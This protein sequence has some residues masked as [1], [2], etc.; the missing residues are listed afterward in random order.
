[1]T[2]D[3]SQ[4]PKS[5][6]IT[7]ADVQHARSRYSSIRAGDDDIEPTEPD[8]DHDVEPTEP[9]DDYDDAGDAAECSPTSPVDDQPDSATEAAAAATAAA[10]AACER[11]QDW[12]PSESGITR[13]R[14]FTSTWS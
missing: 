3:Y 4:L 6:P 13:H 9:D 10:N 11:A 12:T 8:D 2:V 14:S 1:M 7:E 5:P